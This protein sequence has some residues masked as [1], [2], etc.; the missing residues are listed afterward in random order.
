VQRGELAFQVELAIV[1][2]WLWS[3]VVG[4]VDQEDGVV[5]VAGWKV[6]VACA[7]PET[8][9]SGGVDAHVTPSAWVAEVITCSVFAAWADGLVVGLDLNHGGDSAGQRVR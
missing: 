1:A 8:L 2:F 5:G 7:S 6:S 4:L 3:S 9:F